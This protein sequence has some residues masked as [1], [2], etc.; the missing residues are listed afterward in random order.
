M[1]L[2]IYYPP[3]QSCLGITGS[4]IVLLTRNYLF[5]FKM[6]VIFLVA[7]TVL[8]ISFL[9]FFKTQNTIKQCC[10]YRLCDPSHPESENG[11]VLMT[12][13][14]P[15]DRCCFNVNLM[16]EKVSSK[17]Y[18]KIVC[19]DIFPRMSFSF[20]MPSLDLSKMSFTS[21]YIQNTQIH[22]KHTHTQIQ[23][24]TNTLKTT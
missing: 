3:I 6:L 2:I 10:S 20:Q 5:F 17:S 14:R 22:T 8:L 19:S 23:K 11:F 1:L 24:H 4:S 18:L 12:H 7:C 21:A 9:A 13:F 16:F 15:F